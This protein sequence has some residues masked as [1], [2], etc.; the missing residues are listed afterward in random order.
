M[1]D[2]KLFQEHADTEDFLTETFKKFRVLCK[3]MVRYLNLSERVGENIP[4]T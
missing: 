2:M 3:G 4:E 1:E